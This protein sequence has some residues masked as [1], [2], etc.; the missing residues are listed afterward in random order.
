MAQRCA[1]SDR[2]PNEVSFKTV[3]LTGLGISKHVEETVIDPKAWTMGFEKKKK[4]ERPKTVLEAKLEICRKLQDYD[5]PPYN[6]GDVMVELTHKNMGDIAKLIK[7]YKDVEFRN[8][9]KALT[10]WMRQSKHDGKDD[11][12]LWDRLTSAPRVGQQ[13]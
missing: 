6:S 8:F 11:R 10:V 2:N 1:H 12:G 4:I 5:C 13:I 9:D 7:K 3:M